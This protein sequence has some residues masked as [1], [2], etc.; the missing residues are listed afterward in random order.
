MARTSVT[1]RRDD[2]VCCPSVLAAPLAP[3]DAAEL[4]RM[5][6]AL[7]DPARLQVL[8]ILAADV[9]G[10]ICGCDLVEPLGKTQPTVSH[11]LKVLADAGLVRG[12]RRGRWVWYS[13]QTEQLDA[14]R[15]ALDH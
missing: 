7:A 1:T 2:G 14:L 15:R 6:A 11:H 4:A 3:R 5:F 8:S 9:D 13:L 10:E 12:E